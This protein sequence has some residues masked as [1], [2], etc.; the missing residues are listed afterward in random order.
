VASIVGQWREQCAQE[1]T[2]LLD[3]I[4]VRPSSSPSCVRV[5]VRVRWCGRRGVCGG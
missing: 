3:A 1:F 5:R 2:N 4:R